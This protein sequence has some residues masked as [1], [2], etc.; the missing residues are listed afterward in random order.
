MNP[1]LGLGPTAAW[2][3]WGHDTADGTGQPWST[4][5]SYSPSSEAVS[6]ESSRS[7]D[8]LIVPDTEEVT[9]SHPVAPT[10]KALTAEPLASVRS[11]LVRRP[12]KADGDHTGAHAAGSHVDR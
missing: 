6:D 12:V 7:L 3:H 11:G 9:G 10:I 2:A 1:L 5:V 4:A 8:R